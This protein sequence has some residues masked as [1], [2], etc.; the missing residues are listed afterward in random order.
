MTQLPY[1]RQFFGA[2]P[3]QWLLLAFSILEMGFFTF[4]RNALG[5]YASPIVFALLGI[6]IG[7][8]ALWASGRRPKKLAEAE[9][10]GS[11]RTHYILAAVVFVCGTLY[12]MSW[13]RDL[14]AAHPINHLESDVIPALQLH[15]N[16]WL[17][18]G[19][20]LGVYAR[21]DG[22]GYQL[23]PGY[24]PLFWFPFTL[25]EYLGV[26]PRWMSIGFWLLGQGAFMMYLASRR[27]PYAF[28]VLLGVAPFFLLAKMGDTSPQT[29][30]LTV[31]LLAVGYYGILAWGLVRRSFWAQGLGFSLTLLSRF[32]HS[33][34][35]PFYFLGIFF[36][37]NKQWTVKLGVVIGLVG[38]L[39]FVVPYLIPDPEFFPRMGDQY[40][41]AAVGAWST[42]YDQDPRPYD[43]RSGL[44]FALQFYKGDQVPLLDQINALRLTHF[45]VSACVAALLGLGYFLW[46]KKRLYPAF[47]FLFALKIYF[48]FF[49]GF[50]QVP[51]VYLFEVPV[52]LTFWII[53]AAGQGQLGPNEV[54]SVGK[55]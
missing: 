8:V 47:Y 15:A 31:E 4:G 29:L 20:G 39:T 32:G 1:F 50:I 25:S 55:M 10:T 17:G 36:G 41:R 11:L 53:A 54:K 38:L 26:D 28:A 2:R 42:S 30:Y 21:Y 51:Y 45:L 5:H 14:W 35:V 12:T 43:L 34:W 22:F 7:F 52:F 40:K 23:N 9:S 46:G 33:L 27:L 44:G 13:L 24:M 37:R 6:S 16:R 3:Y 19:D 18:G 48:V 49:Y